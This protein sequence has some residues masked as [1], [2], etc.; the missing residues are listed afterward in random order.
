M[1]YQQ[2][3][4]WNCFWKWIV[5]RLS[6]KYS[7]VTLTRTSLIPKQWNE[8]EPKIKPS[9]IFDDGKLP[10]AMALEENSKGSTSQQDILQ[11][12]SWQNAWHDKQS[13]LVEGATPRGRLPPYCGQA[14]FGEGPAPACLIIVLA[15]STKR[16]PQGTMQLTSKSK[17]SCV[18]EH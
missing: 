12:I 5:P 14:I 8:E 17:L 13:R 10:E 9:L 4:N 1:L 3:E 7:L 11:T 16:T 18:G 2:K 15:G 6:S